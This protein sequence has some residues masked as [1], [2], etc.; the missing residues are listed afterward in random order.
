MQLTK[1]TF[2]EGQA[3][4]GDAMD[5]VLDMYDGQ[6]TARHELRQ[7]STVPIGTLPSPTS[8]DSRNHN[9]KG[10]RARHRRAGLGPRLV[11]VPG[12]AGRHARFRAVRRRV[13][14]T[15]LVP[16]PDD[17]VAVRSI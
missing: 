9:L 14:N 11:S 1:L 17:G 7:F 3:Y 8:T 10:L 5:I 4:L 15:A 12:R 6:E 2:S 13:D 16:G